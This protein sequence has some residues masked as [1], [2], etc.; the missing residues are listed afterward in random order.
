MGFLLL[1][2]ASTTVLLKSRERQCGFEDKLWVCSP[3]AS[4]LA[5]RAPNQKLQRLNSHLG[6]GRDLG[7]SVIGRPSDRAAVSGIFDPD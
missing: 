7:M 6:N 5:K 2:H 3:P 1:A 4:T